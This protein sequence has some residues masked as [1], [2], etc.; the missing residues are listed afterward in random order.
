MDIS[1]LV[2]KITLYGLAWTF[3]SCGAAVILAVA[4]FGL[5]EEKNSEENEDD[6]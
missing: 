1:E 6:V 4:F 5:S 2:G 3:V